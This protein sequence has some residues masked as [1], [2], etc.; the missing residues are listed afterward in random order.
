MMK[1]FLPLLLLIFSFSSGKAQFVDLGAQLGLSAYQ[2]D[3]SP[4]EEITSMSAPSLAAGVFG[5]V[6]LV[7][8]I[9]ARLQFSR[10]KIV[11]DDA[12]SDDFFRQQRNLSFR[13]TIHEIA[14]ALEFYPLSGL[15][16]GIWRDFQPYIWGGG[17]LYFHNPQA[18][19][20]GEWYDL[21]PLRTEGQGTSWSEQPEAYELSDFSIPF[22]LGFVLFLDNNINIGLDFGLRATFTDYLDDVSTV[23]ADPTVLSNEVSALSAQL[24]NRTQELPDPQVD[25]GGGVQRGDP[26]DLD[27]YL[28]GGVTVGITLANG[29]SRGRWWGEKRRRNFGF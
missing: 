29:G 17:A 13:S 1:H 6:G 28:F 26:D 2:G 15:N 3:L 24:A 14:L 9:T 7:E 19:L 11:G 20:E 21:H 25:W 18:E 27:W 10:L 5:R 23:Y 22:G 4:R 8:G 12:K 16:Y